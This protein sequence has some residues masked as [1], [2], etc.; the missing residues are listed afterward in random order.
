M[1]P[2]RHRYRR[3]S[4]ER[5]HIARSRSSNSA[6]LAPSPTLVSRLNRFCRARAK[7]SFHFLFGKLHRHRQL[8]Q[9]RGTPQFL[10][11]AHAD[12]S[13]LVER[14]PVMWI[15]AVVA[16]LL[17]NR[18]P[19]WIP[20][21]NHQ[22]GVGGELVAAG[23]GRNFSTRAPDR[24]PRLV[25]RAAHVRLVIFLPTLTTGASLRAHHSAPWARRPQASFRWLSTL[26][27]G[28]G[29]WPTAPG[30]GPGLRHDLQLNL[31][32][33]SRRIRS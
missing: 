21:A 11:S 16:A 2:R 6:V 4:S 33:S 22:L 14:F 25:S 7:R 19:G 30:L 26:A 1:S 29:A 13:W 23:W 15:A 28:P 17:G 12:L 5:C 3:S 10:A 20:L 24:L 32:T 8:A 31:S 18:G 27:S 9:A